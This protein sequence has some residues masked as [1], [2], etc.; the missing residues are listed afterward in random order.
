MKRINFHLFI[1]PNHLNDF[2]L[3]LKKVEKIKHANGNNDHASG[4]YQP[5]LIIGKKRSASSG[6][7]MMYYFFVDFMGRFFHRYHPTFILIYC[8]N[9]KL[10]VMPLSM[11]VILKV[12]PKLP[13]CPRNKQRFPEWKQ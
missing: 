3:K 10:L 12:C 13:V 11:V 7:F 9:L 1:L 8:F 4:E 5:I 2:S 6:C